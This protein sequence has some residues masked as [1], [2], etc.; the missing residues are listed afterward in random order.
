[1][2]SRKNALITPRDLALPT[3]LC[4]LTLD[5]DVFDVQKGCVQP[6]Q[7]PDDTIKPIGFWS[8]SLTDAR[9]KYGTRNKSAS[10]LSAQ[11]FYYAPN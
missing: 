5:I 10:E 8:R 1:M 3:I 7:Q 2:D 4:A 6:N 11:Y 9:R